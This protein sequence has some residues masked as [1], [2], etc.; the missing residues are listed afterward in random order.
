MVK[1]VLEGCDYGIIKV[2]SLEGLRKIMG[3]LSQKS[4]Y[5]DQNLNGASPRSHFSNLPQ[6][7]SLTNNHVDITDIYKLKNIKVQWLVVACC[8]Y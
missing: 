1:V 7:H 2:L 6:H 3:N 5:P 8:S 4:W